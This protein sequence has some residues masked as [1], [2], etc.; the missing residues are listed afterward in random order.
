M[1]AATRRQ[2]ANAGLLQKQGA[3]GEH[4]AVET[5]VAARLIESTTTQ[6]ARAAF[7]A[8]RSEL[9]K[10]VVAGESDLWIVVPHGGREFALARSDRAALQIAGSLLGPRGPAWVVSISKVIADARERYQSHVTDETSIGAAGVRALRP[11][12][13]KP[14]G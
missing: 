11:V 6:R 7:K 13:E 5:A 1:G 8:L 4:D 14:G 12:E 10:A 2:W 9:R 3:F